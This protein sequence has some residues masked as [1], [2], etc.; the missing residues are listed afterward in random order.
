MI[1]RF[2]VET[3]LHDLI[4]IRLRITQENRSK[5]EVYL[6]TELLGVDLLVSWDKYGIESKGIS[7][8]TYH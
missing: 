7:D 3:N 1:R 8:G 2:I 4:D 5:A 6:K